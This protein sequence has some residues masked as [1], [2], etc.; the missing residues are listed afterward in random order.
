[1]PSRCRA[2][3]RLGLPAVAAL[4][5]LAAGCGG[6]SPAAVPQRGLVEYADCVRSHGVPPFPD[7]V[8]GQGIPKDKIPVGNPR[9]AA[10]SNACHR[11]MPVDGLGP[12]TTAAQTRQ[13]VTAEVAFAGCLRS[14][15]F[16]TFPDPTNGGQLSRA[17]I[18]RAGIN[19][20]QPAVLRAADTCTS[21]THG[22]IT[23]A[24]VAGFIAGR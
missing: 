11:V 8:A 7:P 3:T 17:T 13:R 12:Q 4:A 21:V 5:L 22:V 14:H 6:S 10:A 24:A 2:L 1:M 15:G 23:K 16:P 20:Q 19:I 9:L 18:A